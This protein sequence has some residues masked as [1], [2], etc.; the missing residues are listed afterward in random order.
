MLGKLALLL[1]GKLAAAIL[2][3]VLLAGGGATAVLAANGTQ[4]QLP[5][6]SQTASQEHQGN[7]AFDDHGNDQNENELRGTVASV[8]TGSS[9]FVLKQPSGATKTVVVSAQTVFDGGLQRLSDLKAGQ[10]LEVKGNLQSDGTLAATRVHG[11]D[12]DADDDHGGDNGSGD[13][14]GGNS[15]SGSSGSGG[16]GRG[17]HDDTGVDN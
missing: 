9:S 11:E 3:T 6:A 7:D 12:N 15:G 8:N 14:H 13:D 5:L 10:L 1:K 16:S 4:L 2:G 17:G